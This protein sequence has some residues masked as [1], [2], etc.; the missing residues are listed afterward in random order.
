MVDLEQGSYW[1]ALLAFKCAPRP[2]LR[3]AGAFRV[4]DGEPVA[5]RSASDDDRGLLNGLLGIVL[6]DIGKLAQPF[7][8]PQPIANHE[9]IGGFEAYVL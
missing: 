9:F 3:T 1:G 4:A 8:Q 7:V 6:S 5:S 2:W